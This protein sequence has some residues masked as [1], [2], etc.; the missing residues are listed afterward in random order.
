MARDVSELSQAVDAIQ[1]LKYWPRA[2]DY[3][4]NKWLFDK[5]MIIQSTLYMRQYVD[6]GSGGRISFV[7]FRRPF[8]S[9][10]YNSS[11][12]GRWSFQ[13]G[14]DTETESETSR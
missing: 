3:S 7:S 9:K 11:R 5:Y 4:T 8:V 2:N 6:T 12:R 13:P 1:V 14:H 10:Q